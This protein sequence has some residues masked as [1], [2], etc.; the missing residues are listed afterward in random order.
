MSE[1]SNIFENKKILIYGLGKTGIS[2]FK[3]LKKNNFVSIYDDNEKIK[4]KEFITFDKVK[5]SKFD[6]IILSPGININ[7]CKLKKF[8]KKNSK[9]IYTDLDVFSSYFKNQCITITGTNG[10]STTC[11]L[12]HDVLKEKGLDVKLAGN[13]GYPILSIKNIKKNSIFVIEAS[14]Y[15]LEYSKLFSSKYGAILNISV[16]HLERHKTLKN[17]ISAKFKLIENQKKIQ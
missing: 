8:L 10:K 5:K 16:D 6:L 4:K 11:R 15:Q 12:L 3:F 13:I 7:S 14:S 9:S 17:Y 2:A 1:N